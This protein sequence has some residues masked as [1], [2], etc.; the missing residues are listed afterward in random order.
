M[1]R[2]VEMRHQPDPRAP[3]SVRPKE[4]APARRPAGEETAGRD[5]RP[6]RSGAGMG[7]G[8]RRELITVLEARN[9]LGEVPSVSIGTGVVRGGDYLVEITG[10]QEDLRLYDPGEW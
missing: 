4:I 2:P 9:G 3:S 7:A 6:R 10:D 1:A 8:D 5:G